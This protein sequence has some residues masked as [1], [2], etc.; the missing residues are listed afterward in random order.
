M[1]IYRHVLDS[2]GAVGNLMYPPKI[3]SNR[4]TDNPL[5]YRHTSLE[6]AKRRVRAKIARMSR[7]Q[8]RS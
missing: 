6:K 7:R 4:G 1:N 2:L 5:G 8:N 3:G